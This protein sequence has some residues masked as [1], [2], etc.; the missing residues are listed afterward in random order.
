[1]KDKSNFCPICKNREVGELNGI[2][3]YNY[4]GHCQT[5]WLKKTP[6]IKY[7]ETYYQ[8]N[9]SIATILFKPLP[10]FFYWIRKN[11]VAGYNSNIWVD[12]GAGDGSFLKTVKATHKI[13]V[14]V[15]KAGRD[16]MKN[17]GLETMT[18]NQFLESKSLN[19]EVI[20]FW[21]VL[22]HTKEPHKYLMAAYNN[23]SL[24]GKIIIGIPNINSFEFKVFGRYWFH[25]DSNHHLWHFSPYSISLML[26]QVGLVIE[27]IDFWSFE[28]HFAGVLQSFI[29]TTSKTDNTLHRMIKRSNGKTSF[30]LMGILHSIFWL[31]V[32]LSVVVL[33]FIISVIYKRSGTIVIVASKKDD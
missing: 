12:V 15:S 26:D 17:D 16:M 5:A 9:S 11:Y 6:V 8:G 31:T 19:A 1:M 3:W 20:S 7:N 25:L 18:D 14:E 32:G 22:E 10:I 2:S 30:D 29:N 33:F 23:L 21:H 28:H 13:G 4:C 27:K 24:R